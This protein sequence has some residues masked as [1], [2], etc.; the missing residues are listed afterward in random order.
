V[1]ID[2]TGQSID[3]LWQIE[4]ERKPNP[5]WSTWY[6]PEFAAYAGDIPS[7]S[8]SKP[9]SLPGARQRGKKKEKTAL[10]RGKRRFRD[11]DG[12]RPR[13]AIMNEEDDNDEYDGMPGLMSVSASSDDE[14]GPE[15]ESDADDDEE[16]EE[17][18]DDESEWEGTENSKM[19][20]MLA[21]A[22]R[23]YKRRNGKLPEWTEDGEIR[24]GDKDF[25]GNLKTNPFMKMLR[26]FAG[27]HSYLPLFSRLGV[28]IC[29]WM[30]RSRI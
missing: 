9:F 10:V 25:S 15:S 2:E 30:H 14:G 18:E 27:E 4:N 3:S 12:P 28:L 8:E 24:G 5:Q 23:E 13:R 1:Y 21:E 20:A 11:P 16:D 22:M 6:I 26:S 7:D 19:N 17:E 29:L